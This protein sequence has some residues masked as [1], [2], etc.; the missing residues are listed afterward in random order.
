VRPEDPTARAERITAELREVTREA[1]GVLKSLQVAAKNAR[2]MVDEYY[3]D[4]VKTVLDAHTAKWQADIDQFWADAQT[5]I[6]KVVSDAVAR[7]GQIIYT[8]ATLEQLCKAVAVEVAAH[9]VYDQDGPRVH[10]A[11]DHR[12]DPP[13]PH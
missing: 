1:A 11:V 10:Y 5:D 13:G 7:A 12:P 9:T 3:S 4:Q 8:A 2:A 6:K